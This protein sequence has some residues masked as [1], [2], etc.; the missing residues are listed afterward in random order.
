M[1]LTWSLA[2]GIYSLI[3]ATL[4][5]GEV[6]E[7]ELWAIALH[8][9]HSCEDPRIPEGC[10]DVEA[11]NGRGWE[12]ARL[13]RFRAWGRGPRARGLSGPARGPGSLRGVPNAGVLV[14]FV[15]FAHTKS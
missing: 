13:C 4:A 10:Q 1:S 12:E 6:G 2:S 15:N 5:F 9:P 8:L 7:A 11:L 14:G 3:P